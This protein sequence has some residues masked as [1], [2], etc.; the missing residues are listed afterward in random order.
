MIYGLADKLKPLEFAAVLTDHP[1]LGIGNRCR[2]GTFAHWCKEPTAHAPSAVCGA[3]G[4]RQHLACCR[5]GGMNLAWT[6]DRIVAA[7]L[8]IVQWYSLPIHG[9]DTI[10]L[11]ELC[12][13]T[14]R[15]TLNLKPKS[16]IQNYID[17]LPDNSQKSCY[18][19]FAGCRCTSGGY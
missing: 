3:T 11:H 18:Q 9:S 13:L 16:S 7:T 14:I 15:I 17:S 1:R 12:L 2:I 10:V 5:T 19:N 8:K 6:S 4:L